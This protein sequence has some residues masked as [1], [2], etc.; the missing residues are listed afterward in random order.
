MSKEKAGQKVI[1]VNRKAR[2]EYE[3]LDK[4]EAGIELRGS[5]VKSLRGGKLNFAD[6]FASIENNEVWLYNLHIDEYPQAN[7][8]NHEPTRKRRLLLH[9]HQIERFRGKIKEQGLT[10]VPVQLY[11]SGSTI[12]LELALARGKKT[13]DKREAL[14]AKAAKRDMDR[15][16]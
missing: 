3:F 1:A 16:K 5:E 8:F 12:K 11:F 6:S 7:Q 14:K 15:G 2:H 4:L 13:H 9:R 10:L